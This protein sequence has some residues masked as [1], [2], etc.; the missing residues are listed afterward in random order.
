MPSVYLC[1]LPELSIN[2]REKMSNRT[3]LNLTI[4]LGYKRLVKISTYVEKALTNLVLGHSHLRSARGQP[5]AWWCQV[6]KERWA[7]HSLPPPALDKRSHLYHHVAEIYV[8]T[9][10]T[11]T[12]PLLVKTLVFAPPPVN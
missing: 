8:S 5:G 1:E 7:T 2:P 4:F 3:I 6:L 12:S 9:C 11:H 10:L